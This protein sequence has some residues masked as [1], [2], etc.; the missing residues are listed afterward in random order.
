MMKLTINNSQIFPALFLALTNASSN[1]DAVT[2]VSQEKAHHPKKMEDKTKM[3]AFLVSESSGVLHLLT[4]LFPI[5]MNVQNQLPP[6]QK[7]MEDE[8]DMDAFQVQEKF[9]VLHLLTSA[10]PIPMNVQDQLHQQKKLQGSLTW[11]KKRLATHAPKT[12]LEERQA[13]LHS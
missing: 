10:F 9:G 1:A 12:L 13:W 7:K 2:E 6:T 8:T 11:P 4:C 5:S 3:A